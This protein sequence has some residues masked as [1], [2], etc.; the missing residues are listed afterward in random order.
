VLRFQYSMNGYVKVWSTWFQV[1]EA[2]I[3]KRPDVYRAFYRAFTL[4][5]A[6]F[7][8]GVVL[9]PDIWL[10]LT[11]G[12]EHDV[13]VALL[14]APQLALPPAPM[15]AL[16]SAHALS[17]ETWVCLAMATLLALGIS[18]VRAVKVQPLET[19]LR[20]IGNEVAFGALHAALL[21]AYWEAYGW[22]G[23]LS[24]SLSA[25]GT[26]IYNMRR[27][28]MQRTP[29]SHLV[30]VNTPLQKNSMPLGG[31]LGS[32]QWIFN[33]VIEL[34][35]SVLL[36]TIICQRL[37]QFAGLGAVLAASG[38]LMLRMVFW[39]RCAIADLAEH[40]PEHQVTFNTIS[41]LFGSGV[42]AI[43]SFWDY[44]GFWWRPVVDVLSNRSAELTD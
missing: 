26:F 44:T 27:Q 33:V 21:G 15:M 43:C 39:G 20:R 17:A 2:A 34:V 42:L 19:M 3:L 24:I 10:G 13:S 41:E 4:Y 31:A 30:L 38:L 16:P 40:V 29:M 25:I 5:C 35:Y 11:A 7:A 1:S 8:S 18:M 37:L 12:A 28:P 36:L 22:L 32:F 14:A 23:I 9:V 6:A